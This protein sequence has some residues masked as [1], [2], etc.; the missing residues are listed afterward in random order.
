V[1]DLGTLFTP[2]SLTQS[3]DR[4]LSLAD[5]VRAHVM[6]VNRITLPVGNL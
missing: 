3:P 1:P 4:G 2:S 6:W 5:L